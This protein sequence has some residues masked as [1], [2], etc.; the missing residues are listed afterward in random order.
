MN[1]AEE[2]GG[3]RT[4]VAK[5][6][7]KPKPENIPQK[8][9]NLD[10]WVVWRLEKRKGKL[11]K[12]P[13]DAKTGKHASSTDPTTWATFDVAWRAYESGKYS[14]IGFVLNGDG[15]VGGDLDHCVNSEGEMVPTDRGIVERFNSYTEWSPGG[16][17]AR[18]IALGSVPGDRGGHK[19]DG[20]EIYANERYLTIT[21]HRLVKIGDTVLPEE[22]EERQEAVDWF[23]KK[24]FSDE[25]SRPKNEASCSIPAGPIAPKVPNPETI[26]AMIEADGGPGSKLG[27]TF[28]GKRTDLNDTTASGHDQALV[29]LLAHR[30]I[31][32]REMLVGWLWARRQSCGDD[33]EKLCRPDY[34]AG[35]IA[36]A[37]E[38]ISDDDKGD[39]TPEGSN[40]KKGGKGG[41]SIAQ[42]VVKIAEGII[43]DLFH[44][45]TKEAFARVSN[46]GFSANVNLQSDQ[47]KSLLA[48][49][50]YEKKGKVPSA[51]ALNEAITVLRGKA[52]FDRKQ[53]N[54]D[55]RVGW[56]EDEALYYDIAD[57]AGHVVRITASRWEVLAGPPT[58][59]R[60]TAQQ[61][62]QVMPAPQGDVR[63]LLPFLRIDEDEQR[64]R[65]C[66]ELCD[67]VT[68]FVPGIPQ[69]IRVASGAQ[70]SGKSSRELQKKKLV[71]P[72]SCNLSSLN[73][74]R[75]DQAAHQL[76]S[77]YVTVFDNISTINH[78]CSDLFCKVSTGG[79]SFKRKLYSDTDG[80]ILDLRGIL[81]LTGIGS[82]VI[83]FPDLQ[84]RSV[85]FLYDRIDP[86]SR[87]E[88]KEILAEF[89]AAREGILGGIFNTLSKAMD[90]KAK[91][92][93]RYL[94]RMADYCLWGMAVA[95]ALGF[96]ADVFLKAY[97]GNIDKALRDTVRTNVVATLLLDVL[98]DEREFRGT[99][100]ELLGSLNYHRQRKG[101]S[102]DIA[103]W[104]KDP[105][106]LGKKLV[107]LGPALAE[108]GFEVERKRSEGSRE[109]W[110]RKIAD[111]GKEQIESMEP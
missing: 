78:E 108:F 76:N 75:V 1:K 97:R 42:I 71:D 40:P 85:T 107:E 49:C 57:S 102:E 74:Y 7:L 63:A 5:G 11:T 94:P 103:G 81:I 79:T 17:G 80:V 6:V 39:E 82:P 91:L 21:G 38:R 16:E 86:T 9:K 29:S 26:A 25:K 62:P 67:L 110:I 48:K 10:R 41:P 51:Q 72:S 84:D 27:L 77:E 58:R 88:E 36:K 35:T 44:D 52:L 64:G 13:Y 32:D 96:G 69:P 46:N 2:K 100:A 89:E 30:G 61:L 47:F 43:A 50:T 99:M 24:F 104:P 73:P 70:G 12:P 68:R 105:G 3:Q 14:G 55:K 92:T 23:L 15:I 31:T 109:V 22:P 56:G 98:G 90:I 8:L 18:I 101:F 111:H 4:T 33:T 19:A 83:G 95:E 45:Q 20:R 53:I 106:A 34:I 93:T 59:F 54:L 65:A 28:H 66:L 87:R 60:R 37:L